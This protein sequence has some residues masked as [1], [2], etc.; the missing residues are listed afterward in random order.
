[1]CIEGAVFLTTNKQVDEAKLASGLAGLIPERSL[2][3]ELANKSPAAYMLGLEVTAKM[4]P[5]F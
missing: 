4:Q 3:S 5:Q 2:G 1:M